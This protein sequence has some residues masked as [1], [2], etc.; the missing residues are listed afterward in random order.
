LHAVHEKPI[1]IIWDW[2]SEECHN[3]GFYLHSSGITEDKEAPLK[4][5][6]C[7]LGNGILQYIEVL[8]VSKTGLR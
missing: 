6:G 3:V 2:N 1:I 5:D 7:I 4:C 8:E